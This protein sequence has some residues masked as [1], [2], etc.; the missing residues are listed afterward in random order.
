[1][2]MIGARIP[3]RLRLRVLSIVLPAIGLAA[4][5]ALSRA[6]RGAW[7]PI[8][9]DLTVGGATL[10]CVVIF[11]WS[12]FRIIDAQDRF[13]ARQ[14]A[15]LEQRYAMERKQRAQLEALHAASLALA[16]ANIPEDILNSLAASA[17]GLVGAGYAASTLFEADADR[18]ATTPTSLKI[19]VAHGDT[20]VGNLYVGDKRGGTDF[21]REDVQLLQL[22]A[23]HAAIVIEHAQL[24]DQVRTLAVAAERDRIRMDLHDGV[25]QSIYG[26]N[27]ELECAAEDVEA[28]PALARERIDGAIDRLGA[29]IKELRNYILGL[30]AEDP[31]GSLPEALAVLLAQTRAH[32]LLE[33]E[34]RVEGDDMPRLSRGLTQELLKIAREAVANVVRHAHAG[35]VWIT[36]L[37][38][39]GVVHLTI[40]D[41]G[42]G[43]ALAGVSQAGQQGLRNM[44]ERA[45]GSGGVL[46][47][48]SAP[49]AGTSIEVCVPIDN[50]ET[51]GS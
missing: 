30:Q 37:A 41:N 51:G 2:A 5:Y 48:Q 16:A 36:L 19:P 17:R 10:A 38:T 14:Y 32:Y 42:G 43:F 13:V 22:L 29:V 25:M 3:S 20:T 8:V 44:R 18:P 35:R 26:V 1:M 40:A 31:A 33:T 11:S 34:L 45:R 27:L 50:H 47:I 9:V 39:G 4:I 28:A 46:S 23:S 6:L 7:P 24:A 21:T 15:E 12:V 49:G